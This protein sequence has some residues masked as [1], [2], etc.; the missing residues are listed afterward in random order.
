MSDISKI[1]KKFATEYKCKQDSV[2]YY[3][4]E[5]EPFKIYG[6]MRDKNSDCFVRMPTDIAKAV[7]NGVYWLNNKC[8]G[9]R[10]KFITDSSYITIDCMLSGIDK[11]AHIPVTA[12]AGFDI[13]VDGIYENTF[14]PPYDVTTGYEAVVHTYFTEPHEITINFPYFS[15]LDNLYIGLDEKAAVL[16]PKD[17]KISKPVV[18]YGSSI[19]QGACASRPGCT[20]ESILE[21]R[22]DLDYV[23]LG[24]SGNAFGEEAMAEY[25]TGLD[26][27]LF[28]YDYDYNAPSVEHLKN[29][30][31]KMFLKIR[32]KHPDLPII[33]LSIPHFKLDKWK[34]D[35]RAVIEETYKNAIAMGDKNVYFIGGKELMKLAMDNGTVDNCHPNDT[36]FLSMATAIGDLIE[37]NYSEIFK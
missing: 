24:F 23:N 22:F 30:H 26:M 1:D 14:K 31:E 2:K 25:I 21:R 9:G 18:F 11:L 27:S 19:T 37:Q 35:R 4:V 28:V 16:P 17:Y 36:G 5:D 34:L 15:N 33:M 6:V 10:V 8:A 29:T 13:Y 32:E 3:N 20:Y 12:T 7:N